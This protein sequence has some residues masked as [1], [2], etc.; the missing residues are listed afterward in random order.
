MVV[1]RFGVFLVRLDPTQGHEMQKTRPCVVVSPNE[2]NH[3]ATVIV[4]PMTTGG[5]PYPSRVTTTFRGKKGW[6]VLARFGPSTRRDWSSA[7]GS[8][9]Q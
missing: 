1:G 6:I 2:M 3:I 7:S 4:A 8:L 9:M 5:Q